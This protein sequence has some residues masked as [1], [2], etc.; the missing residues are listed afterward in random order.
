L[1]AAASY[2]AR[3]PRAACRHAC[4][5][6]KKATTLAK[7]EENSWPMHDELIILTRCF[8]LLAWLVPKSETFPKVHRHTV[9][10]RLRSC[11]FA[12]ARRPER[13]A[14]NA[15]RKPT[16]GSTNCACTCGWHTIG[17]G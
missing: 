14:G 12:R 4:I 7:S 16:R 13:H 2:E 6:F 17:T 9:V 15:C 5:R 10:Q 11:C 3:L 8:D 1:K